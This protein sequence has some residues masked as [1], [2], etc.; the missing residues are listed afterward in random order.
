MKKISK[1]EEKNEKELK[2]AEYFYAVGRRKTA[3]AK[4]KLFVVESGQNTF[5]IN[6]RKSEEYFPISRLDSL[7]KSPLELAGEGLKFEAIVNVFGGGISAQADAVKLG[8]ARALV[9]YNEELKKSLKSKGFL[10]RDPREVERKK[11]GLKKARKAP[12]WAKR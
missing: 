7:I 2:N 8:V 6:E 12:Q 9:V 3:I 11:P 5:V 10:T 4:V 1:K